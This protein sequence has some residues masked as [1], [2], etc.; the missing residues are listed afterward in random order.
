MLIQTFD[1]L[2]T[3]ARQQPDAQRLLFV[4]A[5]AELP[6]DAS[7]EQK[8][9]YRDGIGGALT[10]LMEVNKLPDELRDFEHLIS[11]SMEFAKGTR[12]EEW[13]MV[14]CAALGGDGSRPPAR[15]DAD[16][17]LRQMTNAIRMGEIDR[18]IVFDRMGHQVRLTQS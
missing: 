2:L 18:Y 16:L 3:T 12:A 5:I 9:R 14:F 10:P 6:E 17:P 8:K 4:F 7:L 11:E 15:E 13:S 1:D